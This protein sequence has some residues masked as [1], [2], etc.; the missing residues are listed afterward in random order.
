MRIRILVVMLLICLVS[1]FAPGQNG[2][3]Q[4]ISIDKDKL[5]VSCDGKA[6]LTYSYRS[7]PA[8]PYV[9]RLTTPGGVNILRDAPHDHLHHHALMMALGV[10]RP[11]YTIVL[12]KVRLCLEASYPLK[13]LG[14]RSC[15]ASSISGSIVTT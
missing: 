14:Q 11:I 13:I 7:V 10:F 2:S 8:K 9:K 4:T 5:T 15:T 3:T 1:N 12:R 6:G